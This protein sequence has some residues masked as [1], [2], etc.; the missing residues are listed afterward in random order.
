MSVGADAGE[1]SLAYVVAFQHAIL[2]TVSGGAGFRDFRA[3]DAPAV[4][5]GTSTHAFHS[6]WNATV[7]RFA[8][9]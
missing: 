8:T 1:F 5:P 4:S 7:T 9:P 3:D 6:N 2:H